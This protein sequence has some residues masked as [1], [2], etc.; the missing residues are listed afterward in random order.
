MKELYPIVWGLR[1]QPSKAIGQSPFFLVYG[2]EAVLPV[3]MIFGAPH[4]QHYDEGEIEQQWRLDVD[5]TEE[6]RLSA[7]LHN[8]VYLQ[9][10][11]KCHD[12]HV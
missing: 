10:I 6:A 12:K 1:T 8:A 2:S 9:G 11:R 7:L 5:T 3:D 4:V